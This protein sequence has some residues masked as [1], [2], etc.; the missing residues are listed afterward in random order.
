VWIRCQAN[1]GLHRQ[2]ETFFAAKRR[3]SQVIAQ[4]LVYGQSRV[5]RSLRQQDDKFV[6]AVAESKVIEPQLRFNVISDF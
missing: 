6:A 2:V 4:A 5:L 1:A 3:G